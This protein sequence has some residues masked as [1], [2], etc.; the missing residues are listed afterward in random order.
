[1]GADCKSQY[2]AGRPHLTWRSAIHKVT[3][4]ADIVQPDRSRYV[5]DSNSAAHPFQASR[6]AKQFWV[7]RTSCDGETSVWMQ[8]P[9]AQQVEIGSTIHL[10]F[11]KFQS[12]DLAFYLPATPRGLEG[13]PPI[14][15]CSS[16]AWAH[17]WRNLPSRYWSCG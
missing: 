7:L 2:F 6:G 9:G 13:R 15:L 12:V 8:Y 17:L 11:E 5:E 10:T 1:M 3:H 14:L 16:D 4:A